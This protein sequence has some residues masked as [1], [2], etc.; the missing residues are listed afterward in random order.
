[1]SVTYPSTPAFRAVNLR[2]IDPTIV[3]RSQNGRRITRKVGGQLW[4]FTLTYPPMTKDQFKPILGALAKARGMYQ[5]FTIIPPNL[6]T[7]SGTQLSDTTVA[8]SA[9]VGET[10]ISLSGATASATFKAGDVIKFSNHN[11]VY[12]IT[13]DATADGSGNATVS[14]SP[15]LVS[16]ITA[17]SHS[18]KHSNVPFNVA[19]SNDIQEIKTD[20]FG[21][22]MYELD[23]EEVF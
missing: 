8:T 18:A 17:T 7:P 4:A 22:N 10:S 2:I 15:P 16:A 12:M 11:K 20:V 3:F 23:V 9:A 5:T 1:M 14:I 13:D 21:L 19:L 6:A